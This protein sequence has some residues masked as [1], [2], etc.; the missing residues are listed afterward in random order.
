[1]SKKN[2]RK[3]NSARKNEEKLYDMKIIMLTPAF[4]N[5]LS[6]DNSVFINIFNKFNPE[7]QSIIKNLMEASNDEDP[8]ILVSSKLNLIANVPST[9]FDEMD[10]IKINWQALYF[11]ISTF[12]DALIQSNF[13][14]LGFL[15]LADHISLKNFIYGMG[16]F[17]SDLKKNNLY[18]SEVKV[19]M[20]TMESMIQRY[21]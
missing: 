12:M 3:N 17:K 11:V 13:I 20:N 6:K 7:L 8:N 18:D 9:D 2:A 19:A 5:L 4:A 14:I 15:Q 10:S 21:I 1:M 16:L